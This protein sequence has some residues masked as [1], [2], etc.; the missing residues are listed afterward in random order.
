MISKLLFYI[1]STSYAVS[2]YYKYYIPSNSW[3]NKY[4][5]D[6]VCMPIVF[7]IA[8][9]S[10]QFVKK[11]KT[12]KLSSLQIIAGVAYYSVLFEVIAPQ[13]NTKYTADIFDVVCYSIGAFG[14]WIWQKATP[15]KD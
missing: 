7:A 11:N 1:L 4:W 6:L 3:F 12:L 13:F 2:V 15:F 5:A 8:L 10:I 14:F 9:K